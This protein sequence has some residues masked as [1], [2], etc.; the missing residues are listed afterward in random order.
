MKNNHAIYPSRV[1]NIIFWG[2]A[3]ALWLPHFV[4]PP[5]FRPSDWS[6]SILFRLIITGL[7]TWLAYLFFY[8]REIS[9]SIPGRKNSAALPWLLLL[10]FFAIS[11]ISTVFSQDTLFSFFGGPARSGGILMLLFFLAFIAVAA[12]FVKGED[13]EKLMHAN[14]IVGI[15]A[16]LFAII[17][18]F[19]LFGDILVSWAAGGP[20]SF[21]GSST[22]LAIYMIFLLFSAAALLLKTTE[23]SK[24]M[25]YAG[26]A[27]LFLICILVTGS[28]A[29]Y[30]AVLAGGAYLL[31]FLPISA[32]AGNTSLVKKIRYAKIAA[33]ALG[34]LALLALIYINTSPTLP[35]F[36]E[37]NAR[38]SY[39]V[40]DRLSFKVVA[41]DLLGTRFS[42][43]K[44]T[45]QAIMEKPW[46]GFGPENFHIG[47]E[48]Y[49]DPKLPPSLQKLWFDR[50]HNIF[51]EIWANSGIFALLAYLAFWTVLLW[52][53]HQHKKSQPENRLKIFPHAL[54][55]MFIAY[56]IAL[57]FNFD[58]FATWIAS[59]FFV[60]F[61]LYLLAEPGEKITFLPPKKP[62]RAGAVIA[63]VA[64]PS[65]ALF[66]W[67][68][69]IKPLYL[70]ERMSYAS[71]MADDKR[72]T[73]ALAIADTTNLKHSGILKSSNNLLYSE[74]IKNCTW[75]VPEKEATNSAKAL[76]M[77]QIASAYQPGFSRTWLFMGGFANVLAAREENLQKRQE[78][79]TKAHEYLKKARQL[80]PG[81]QE[82]L[83]ELEKSYLV[84]EDFAM[85]EKTG[86]ECTAI[87]PELG[88]CYWYQGV[89]QVFLG[90]Q[91]EGAKNVAL[92]K[93]KGYNN[94]PHKQLAIAYIQQ[95]NWKEAV[96]EYERIDI[97]TNPEQA[98]SHHAT[99]A[100]LYRQAGD[101]TAAGQEALKVFK[102]QP[103]NPETLPF[104]IALL[105]VSPNDPVLH[106]SLA[107]VYTQT[108]QDAKALQEI[109]TAK[110]IY[111]RLVKTNPNNWDYHWSLAG[112][113]HTLKEYDRAYQEALITLKLR[114][115]LQK[116]IEDL[117][118][119]MPEKYWTEY[120]YERSR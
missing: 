71:H 40:H 84:A 39:I 106:T 95:K 26:L 28:R 7:I 35:S 62:L 34:A 16:S 98:A 8:K 58:S 63:L 37:N 23:K 29:T 118:S 96:I 97:P 24:R 10:A 2:L 52:K 49:F 105:G 44:I 30:L 27:T 88:E 54:Q 59:F 55:A 41:T 67:F 81:R 20:P 32:H 116:P 85:M 14:F 6:R 47:F 103:E 100:Y 78:W 9:F 117:L 65:L 89:A 61:A 102:A 114:P 77:L 66:I 83:L 53:L 112:I 94:P 46:L 110:N 108:G 19:G 51:L 101:Y 107:Y 33:L 13:W 50:P 68:W 120:T 115:D 92:S 45:W 43:W 48:T 109:I 111:L 15:A 11:L 79:L 64:V 90:K 38:I 36:I 87:D 1:R 21:I 93:E 86:Q 75:T 80:S 69:N 72:C 74:I 99:L 22:A 60:A 57:F 3:A 113:S 17:Q 5:S 91:E 31:F 18:Y 76:S 4:F 42:A 56:L 70:F 73:E 119:R 25:W 104:L 12:F 82:M